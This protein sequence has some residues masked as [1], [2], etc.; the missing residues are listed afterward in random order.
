MRTYPSGRRRVP[1][2]VDSYTF[3]IAILL[4]SLCILIALA[5]CGGDPPPVKTC[6]RATCGEATAAT[7]AHCF[8][9]AY[10][11][12]GQTSASF[13]SQDGLTVFTVDESCEVVWSNAGQ[14]RVCRGLSLSGDLLDPAACP[15]LTP[16]DCGPA[17]SR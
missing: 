1:Q 12:C 2:V 15:W 3:E 13:V 6:G 16:S 14:E 11:R 5:G 10:Q 9:S 7:A 4:I 8:L 17:I